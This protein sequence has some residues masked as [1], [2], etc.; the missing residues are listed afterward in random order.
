[1]PER[2]KQIGS[3]IYI[4]KKDV[5]H[6]PR[7]VSHSRSTEKAERVRFCED[8]PDVPDTRA[9]AEI[10]L[11]DNRGQARG[12]RFAGRRTSRPVAAGEPGSVALGWPRPFHVTSA[13]AVWTPRTK[14]KFKSACGGIAPG[15]GSWVTLLTRA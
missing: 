4:L 5:P 14:A 8:V 7:I 3:Y 2:E 13:I 11:L 15:Q 10:D 1:M 6:V 12:W 9:A